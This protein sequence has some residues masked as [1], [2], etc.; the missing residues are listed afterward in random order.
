MDTITKNGVPW[1]FPLPIRFG[2][3]P[4]RFMRISTGTFMEK[5]GVYSSLLGLNIYLIY[6]NYGKFLDFFG[7]RIVR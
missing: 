4:F 3:P 6:S 7:N 2:F 5:V 1:L